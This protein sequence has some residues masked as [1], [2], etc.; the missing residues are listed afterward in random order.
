MVDDLLVDDLL[1]DDL[2]I[3]N[4][5][6][7]DLLINNLLVDDPLVDSDQYPQPPTSHQDQ[8]QETPGAGSRWQADRAGV[9]SA[10]GGLQETG[11][12]NA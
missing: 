2:L 5:L 12:G 9:V 3:D 8:L 6:I 4:L 10:W 11:D 1:V 7:N